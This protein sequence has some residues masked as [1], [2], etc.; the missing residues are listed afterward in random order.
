[1]PTLDQDPLPLYYL[2]IF[3][4]G[5]FIVW[6][7]GYYIVS[8]HG[9]MKKMSAI[10]EELGRIVAVHDEKHEQHE[11]EIIELRYNGKRKML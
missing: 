8:T 3:L 1:M 5:S 11:K 9:Y 2:I 4:F 6:G 7:I 10:V